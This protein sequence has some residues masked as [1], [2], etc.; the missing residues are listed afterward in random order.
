MAPHWWVDLACGSVAASGRLVFTPLLPCGWLGRT[1]AMEMHGKVHPLRWL[2]PK[3]TYGINGR[4]GSMLTLPSV[5]ICRSNQSVFRGLGL[6]E[7]PAGLNFWRPHQNILLGDELEPGMTLLQQSAQLPL[8]VV[9][10]GRPHGLHVT[11]VGR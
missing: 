3:N 11:G 9:G 10:V 1:L 2:L 4:P 7:P 5:P 8:L 6:P